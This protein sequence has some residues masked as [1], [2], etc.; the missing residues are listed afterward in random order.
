MKRIRASL[1]ISS[2]FSVFV[3][4]FFRCAFSLASLLQHMYGNKYIACR[5][6]FGVSSPAPRSSPYRWCFFRSSRMLA[7]IYIYTRSLTLSLSNFLVFRRAFESVSLS[8]VCLP[9]IYISTMML[10]MVHK[11]PFVVSQQ[12]SFSS[13]PLCCY[14]NCCCNKLNNDTKTSIDSRGF[15]DPVHWSVSTVSWCERMCRV[16]LWR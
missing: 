9:A 10:N 2:H 7:L 12:R 8:L 16:M 1:S 14:F 4:G 13:L 11:I 6:L 15:A 5:P 3:S